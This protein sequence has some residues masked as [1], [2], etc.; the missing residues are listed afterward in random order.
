MRSIAALIPLTFVLAGGATAENRHVAKGLFCN[1]HEQ[2]AEV[3]GS[4]G[5]G[6]PL[7]EAI[8]VENRENIVCVWA[9]AIGYMLTDPEP[10]PRVTHGSGWVGVYRAR[11]IGVLVGENPR[12]IDPPV[13]IFFVP[14]ENLP[15][16]LLTRNS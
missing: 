10:S 11:L 15:A 5:A 2:I 13:E 3:F 7:A 16:S 6:L 8:A 9:D 1:T 14:L 12:P 4:L